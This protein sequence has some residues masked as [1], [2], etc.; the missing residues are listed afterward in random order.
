VWEFDDR[1]RREVTADR[2]VLCEVILEAV[3]KAL[4]KIKNTLF[5]K[6]ALTRYLLLYVIR[7]I[8]ESDEMFSEIS[9]KPGKFVKDAADRDHFRTCVTTILDDVVIDL[10]SEMY[11]QGENFYYRDSLRD[12]KWV[13]DISKRVVADHSKLVQRGRILSFKDEWLASTEMP[14]QGSP[15]GARVG[16]P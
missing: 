4:P 6:Y 1:S 8:L 10:N 5:G 12:P 3:D 14:V 16:E 13:G 2:I 15:D 7:E 9:E 11:D